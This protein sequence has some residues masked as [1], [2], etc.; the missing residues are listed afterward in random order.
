[1]SQQNNNQARQ[2]TSYGSPHS[3][4]SPSMQAYAYPPP[5]QQQNV[6]PYRNSPTGSNVSLPSLNLPPI[7]NINQSGQQQ[8]GQQQQQPTTPQQQPAVPAPV[9]SPLPP[10][11]GNMGPYYPQPPGQNMPQMSVTSNQP[12]RYALPAA[13]DARIMSGGRHKKEIKRRTKTGCLTCRK[14]R[15]KCDEG[16]PT[17]RNCQKSKRECL[18]YDP[19]FKPQPGPAAIQPAPAASATPVQAPPATS[20][21]YPPPPQGYMPA[22]TQNFA[23]T[24]T[25]AISNSPVPS[26]EPFEYGAAIDPALEGAS[27]T[28][29]NPANTFDAIKS[30]PDTKTTL[31]NGNV[32]PSATSEEAN[33]KAKRIEMNDIFAIGRSGVTAQLPE[34][35][36][37]NPQHYGD[38]TNLYV[39]FFA[40][41]LDKFFETHWFRQRSL[42]LLVADTNLCERFA[43]LLDRY[44]VPLDQL[45]N[46]HKITK[47]LE[48]SIL[49]SLMCL[50]R[51]RNET[52]D[53]MPEEERRGHIADGLLTVLPRLDIFQALLEGRY[54]DENPL[55]PSE[56]PVT[57]SALD[58]KLKYHEMEFWRLMG[59]FLTLR[60]NEASSAKAID[61][62][63][64]E[65]RKLLQSH[66]NRDLLYSIAVVRH[67]GQRMNEF[68]NSM[69]HPTTNTEDDPVNKVIIAKK[70]I[71]NETFRGTNQVVSRIADMTVWSWTLWH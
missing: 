14:R 6:E 44:K 32:Y 53:S 23:Q 20:S 24:L 36:I 45:P 71:E 48:T 11:M 3:Y 62:T 51:K 63:L 41:G 52:I 65:C 29:S 38:I 46:E 10:S 68:P 60:D 22:S 56:Y 35:S 37:P 57:G 1:M 27:S 49:W 43:A 12:M 34:R 9:G 40:P 16:H 58:K 5:Q 47:S 26:I 42:P 33:Q 50:C 19:I 25:A 18:G 61:D 64:A 28:M 59:Q 17:C 69:P 67:F 39:E 55:P 66:E 7:R 30:E 15:I 4:P 8:P 54:L 31:G 2:P 21:P 70:F 13:P